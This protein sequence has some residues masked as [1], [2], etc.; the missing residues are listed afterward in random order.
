MSEIL[1]SKHRAE[2][3]VRSRKTG[4]VSIHSGRYGL[5]YEAYNLCMRKGYELLQ[6]TAI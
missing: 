5:F 4:K 2:I 3:V 1:E 6:Y